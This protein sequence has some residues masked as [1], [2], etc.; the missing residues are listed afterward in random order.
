MSWIKTFINRFGLE[1]NIG[2]RGERVAARH[3]RHLG[4]RILARNL[5]TRAGEIDL[6]AQAPDRRTIV[7]VEV[8]SA[9]NDQ[10]DQPLDPRPEEHVHYFKQR[11]LTALACQI[12]RRYNLGGLPI[13]FDVVGVEF[14]DDAPP[15]VRHHPGAFESQV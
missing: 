1:R 11:R 9:V 12:A 13:R 8:K 10:P 6:L 5:R 3:L 7:V 2:A 4:Y 14:P 15:V